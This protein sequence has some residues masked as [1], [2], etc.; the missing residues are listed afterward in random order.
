MVSL[1]YSMGSALFKRIPGPAY[2]LQ[3]FQAVPGVTDWL[4]PVAKIAQV[5]NELLVRTVVRGFEIFASAKKVSVSLP[6]F[7]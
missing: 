1:K 2:H 6:N 4:R 7:V 5:M 3:G